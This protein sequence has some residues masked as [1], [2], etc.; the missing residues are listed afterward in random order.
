[1]L[2]RASGRAKVIQVIGDTGTDAYTAA[3]A[4]GLVFPARVG[5][6]CGLDVHVLA[7][8]ALTQLGFGFIEV[9]P[10]TLKPIA[11]KAIA[12]RRGHRD[13]V[14]EEPLANDGS[15]ALAGRVRRCGD[16]RVGMRLAH[17]P[18]IPAAAVVNEVTQLARIFADR[19]DFFTYDT[20]AALSD[21]HSAQGENETVRLALQAIRAAAPSCPLFLSLPP[22]VP[23]SRME[24]WIG[25]AKLCGAVGIVVG[26]GVATPDGRLV[27][28]STFAQSIALVQAVRKRFPTE[29][30]VIGSGGVFEPADALAMLDAGADLVQIHS[31]LVYAGPNLAK[32]ITRASPRSTVPRLVETNAWVWILLMG[33]GIAIAGTVAW[34]IGSTRVILPYDEHFLGLTLEQIARINARLP[35]FMQHDRVTYAGA[36]L[37]AGLAYVFIA[38][39]GLR[40]GIPWARRVIVYSSVVG[41][42]SFFLLL[43][44]HYLD[45]VHAAGTAVFLAFFAIGAAS[46]AR[47]NRAV[48]RDLQNDKAWLW[49]QLCF[50][51]LGF[52]FVVGG[53]TICVVGVS[54]LFVP[55]DLTFMH[56]TREVL[57]AASPRLIPLLAHDRAYFGGT[58]IVNGIIWLLAA[59]WGFDRGV[60]WLW[61]MFALSGLPG[62]A[63]AIAVHFGV[64]YTDFMHLLPVY[65]ALILFI[66][67]L[68][69]SRRYLK[70]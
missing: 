43:G 41:F 46:P 67:G 6:G 63:A 51:F 30:C 24:T 40:A 64:G 25:E 39:F 44:I 14:Y 37:S 50:V 21:N 56:T 20:R 23:R 69:C 10:V 29:L 60:R 16:V 53:I 8:D 54:S 3:N 66:T 28:R 36:L 57:A 9:G 18:G 70:G 58:L 52:G 59:L 55:S 33:I 47:I 2:A 45:P 34:F 1:M 12:L 22:D 4:A 11:E 61:W 7:N 38:A 15:V 27:G 65:F 48:S 49:G 62:F 68:A 31:G 35:V 17:R 42:A 19:A 5:L 26:G 13:I 32:R